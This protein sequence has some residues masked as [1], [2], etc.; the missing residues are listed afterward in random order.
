MFQCI[1]C[2]QDPTLHSFSI[3]DDSDTHTTYHS[4]ISQAKDTDI[5]RILSHMEGYLNYQ[6]VH[7]PTKTWSWEID[8]TNFTIEWH[9][10]DL[11][12]ELFD[13]MKKY[14]SNFKECRVKNMNSWLK[15]IYDTAIPYVCDS[16]RSYLI[17]E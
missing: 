1:H 11:T 4:V 3:K 14:K 7:H 9:S 17:F 15:Y 10:L 13:L 5:N 6:R 8:G 12:I 2:I 16:L